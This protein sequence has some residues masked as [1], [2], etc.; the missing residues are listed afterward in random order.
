[1]L[2][3][4]GLPENISTLFCTPVQGWIGMSGVSVGASPPETGPV[5]S[6]VLRRSK[7]ARDVRGS[8]RFGL[9][10]GVYDKGY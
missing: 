10:C 4:L 5:L 2:G 7:V 9:G 8:I 3:N 6:Y 1:V